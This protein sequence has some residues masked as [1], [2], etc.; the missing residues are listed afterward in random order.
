MLHYMFGPPDAGGEMEGLRRQIPRWN[1]G[2][3]VLHRD[4]PADIANLLVVVDAMRYALLDI[5]GCALCLLAIP[6][7]RRPMSAD[8]FEPFYVPT[9]DLVFPQE[10]GLVIRFVPPDVSPDSFVPW[11]PRIAGGRG[12]YSSDIHLFRPPPDTL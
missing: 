1:V 7:I 9:D 11:C 5:A 10:K 4:A 2:S 8:P 3:L 6:Y 12:K